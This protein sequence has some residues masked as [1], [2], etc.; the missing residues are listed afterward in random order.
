MTIKQNE[1]QLFLGVELGMGKY[2]DNVFII[3]SPS[4]KLEARKW[5]A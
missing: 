2:S 3:I 5:L 1:K 4:M